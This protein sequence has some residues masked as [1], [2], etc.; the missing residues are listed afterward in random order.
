[1]QDE[2]SSNSNPSGVKGI[3]PEGWH[4]PS[5]TEWAVMAEHYGGH[6]D[7]SGDNGEAAYNALKKGGYSGLG[8]VLG[9]YGKSEFAS[10]VIS[11]FVN[12]DKVGY[13]WSSTA[14]GFSNFIQIYE[15]NKVQEGLIRSNSYS[16][17]NANS[18]R[19]V[20]D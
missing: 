19:C 18:C 12:D 8:L 10:W 15:L 5:D 4:V 7:D 9:G 14:T 6:K 11:E 13:Y 16:S 3:C 1:M 17:G 2:V 20:H